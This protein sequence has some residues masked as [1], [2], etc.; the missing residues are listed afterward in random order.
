[1][2]V[3]FHKDYW[4]LWALALGLALFFPV[5]QLIWVLYIRRAERAGPVEE[6]ERRRLKRRAGA[7]SALICFLF[8]LVYTQ[9]LFSGQP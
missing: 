9:P 1:M 3:L 6:G 5:R 7:T 8:A 2:E 4:L